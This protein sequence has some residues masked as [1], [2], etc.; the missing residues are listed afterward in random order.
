[1]EK[2]KKN[3]RSS[4]GNTYGELEF[5]EVAPLIFPALDKL[6]EQTGEEGVRKRDKLKKKA[7]FVDEYWDKRARA[8]FVSHLL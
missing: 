2:I 5:P 8:K 7:K 3:F 6:A 4:S 1:M